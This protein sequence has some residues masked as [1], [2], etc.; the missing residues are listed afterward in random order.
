MF[1][2]EAEEVPLD[3]H[4]RY[5]ARAKVYEYRIL[6]R[7]DPDL[8]NRRFVWHVKRHLR[9]DFLTACL[10][11]I[12]GEHDFASFASSGGSA[13]TTIRTI[14]DAHLE[15]SG[16]TY[17]FRVCGNGFLRHMVRNLVGSMVELDLQN[18]TVEDFQGILR[19]RDRRKAGLN[20]PAQGLF[21]VD[22]YYGDFEGPF[23]EAST[24]S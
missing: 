14:Y 20:A 19:A 15:V 21:L 12:V 8:F 2:K 24:V 23:K 22:I 7:Q 17:V 4:A 18:M 6:N 11:K 13:K 5:G 1:I 9:P 3:F 16:D 10:E